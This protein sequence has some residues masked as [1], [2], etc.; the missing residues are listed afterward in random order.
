MASDLIVKDNRLIKAKYNLTKTQAKFI[1][2]MASK[3]TKDDMEFFTYSTTLKELLNMLSIE[4]K[5]IKRLDIDLTDLMQKIIVIQD[6]E[7][8]IEKTALLSYFKIDIKNNKVEYRFDKSMQLFLVNLQSNFTK[9]SLEQI[10]RFDSSYTIRMYE[11][12]EQKAKLLEKYKNKDLITF[13]I[14]LQELKEIL[15]GEY[16]KGI[17]VVP[18]SYSLYG[19]FKNKILEVTYKELKEKG[20]YYF[21]Y[22]ALKE[23]R[24]VTSIKFTIKT[25]KEKIKADFKER[26]RTHLLNGK[27]K[28]LAQEQI[29]RIVERTKTI[30]DPIKFEAALFTK[31]LKGTLNYDKDL[32]EIKSS[33]DR[34]ELENILNDISDEKIVK[35]KVKKLSEQEARVEKFKAGLKKDRENM[36]KDKE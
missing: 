24:S 22:E 10:F 1:A 30:L 12:L 11:I 20:D 21:E 28:Q 36:K 9:L 27:E 17:V 19:N 29:R 25:N 7:E 23:S 6:D 14:D 26:K 13:E 18:K 15:A 32:A 16:K 35:E 4:R 2:Y 3:I 5:H 31:Y 34:K 8:V 33:L